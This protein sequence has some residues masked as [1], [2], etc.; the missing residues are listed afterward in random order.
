MAQ[1]FDVTF[2]YLFRQSRGVLATMLFGDSFEWQ[3]VEQPAVR[4]LRA[5]LLAKCADGTYRQVE[6]QVTNDRGL[7]FR[8]LEYYVGFYR[9]LGEHVQ[10]TVL[11]A[12][13]EPLRMD[14][15]FHSPSTQHRYT[16]LNLREMDGDELLASEDLADN[17]WALLTKTD[18]EKVIR[19]VIDKLRTLSGEE[20]EKAA[21]TFVII[22]GI[23]GIEAEVE[24][25]LQTDMIDLL[26][27]K[28]LGP[29]IRKGLAQGLEQGRQEGRQEGLQEG[30][31][32]G[33]QAGL[34]AG[35]HQVLHALLERRSAALP[36]GASA[37][38]ASASAEAL[39]AWILR[40]DAGE[41]LE[42][43]FAEPS[44]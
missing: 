2:K 35:L 30:R 29:A 34:Q 20:Q 13:R 1:T 27:N 44:K 8:M 12:G 28:V 4:N 31:Q 16:N 36:P 15:A 7:A 10:Q 32:E 25:R 18:P 38:V 9:S 43:I 22:G 11:Y 23:L 41:S 39:N 5:D 21:S 26:E 17:Q 42:K 6:L 33:L 19:V 40:L 37:R 3:N 14:D 24:R